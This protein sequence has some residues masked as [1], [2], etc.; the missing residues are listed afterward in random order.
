MIMSLGNILG[1]L[2]AGALGDLLPIRGI[3]LALMGVNLLAVFGIM[4]RGRRHVA[5]IYNR[6][7]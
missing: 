5:A 1:T 4:Y 2:I 7:V 3:I 6:D